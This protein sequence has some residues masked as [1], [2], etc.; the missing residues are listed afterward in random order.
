M[1]EAVSGIYVAGDIWLK[2][3]AEP[4]GAAPLS[5]RQDVVELQE[6]GL[7]FGG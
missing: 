4:G 6:A 3:S 1:E 5:W 2:G 7:L